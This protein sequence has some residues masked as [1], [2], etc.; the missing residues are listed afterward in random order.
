MPAS[1]QS[2]RKALAGSIL[3]AWTAG[4]NAARIAT[5]KV[6]EAAMASVRGSFG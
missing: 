6:A 5:A 1:D 3:A 2:L 4:S